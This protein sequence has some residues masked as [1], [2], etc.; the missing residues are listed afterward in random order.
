VGRSRDGSLAAPPCKHASEK[1]N[2]KKDQCEDGKRRLMNE[3][4]GEKV[5]DKCETRYDGKQQ[6]EEAG[7]S[8]A[9]KQL[10]RRFERCK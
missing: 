9:K 3:M 4:L 5:F 10:F 6:Y 1:Q 8:D 7:A 2:P